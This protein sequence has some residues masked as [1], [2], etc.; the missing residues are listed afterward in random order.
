MMDVIDV[1]FCLLNC[2]NF[3]FSVIGQV[4]C[5]QVNALGKKFIEMHKN[6]AYAY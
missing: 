4:W 6:K 3:Y 5:Y 2:M 1:N